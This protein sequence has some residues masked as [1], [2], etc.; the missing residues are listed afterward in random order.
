MLQSCLE[1]PSVYSRKILS[2]L[3]IA[4]CLLS[5]STLVSTQV[6]YTPIGI[7]VRRRLSCYTVLDCVTS[8]CSAAKQENIP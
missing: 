6:L 4:V 5:T 7:L 8:M 1:L 2:V 3:C